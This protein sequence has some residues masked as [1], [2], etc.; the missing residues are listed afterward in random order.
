M[1][2][3]ELIM[4]YFVLHPKQDLKH[5]PVVDYV[6]SEYVKLYGKKPRDTW[7]AIRSLYQI[8]FLIKVSKGVYRYDPGYVQTRELHEFNQETKNK[9][10]GRDNYKCVV[11]GRGVG[12]GVEICVDHKVPK[13]KGGTDTIDN[14]QTLCTEHNLLK[15]N[16]SQTEFGKRFLIKLYKDAVR[17]NDEKIVRFCQEIFDVYDKYGVNG[18]ISRP[19]HK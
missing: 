4:K 7:R 5:G 12:D 14:G 15:K 8:G 2:I 13:D 3:Q 6:E 11:C 17:N 19:N 1:E 9:I 18:H 10:F 16:Y